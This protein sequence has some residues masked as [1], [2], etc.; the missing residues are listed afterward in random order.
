MHQQTGSCEIK[1]N[2]TNPVRLCPGLERV[3]L[4]ETNVL[5]VHEP[6]GSKSQWLLLF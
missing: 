5:L 6:L 1:K 3:P 4:K 2:K